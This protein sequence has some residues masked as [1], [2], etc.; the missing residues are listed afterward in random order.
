MG[1]AS[2]SAS[3]A[4]GARS[5]ITPAATASAGA[6]KAGK[7]GSIVAPASVATAV[8]AAGA[9]R[10]SVLCVG[11]TLSTFVERL[12]TANAARSSFASAAAGG[13]FAG[14]WASA[15]SSASSSRLGR[16]GR[17]V[18]SGGGPDSIVPAICCSGTPQNGC[19]AA[20]ASQRRIPTAQ[21]SLAGQ[22]SSP[23]RRSGE[24]YASVPG[25]SP[26]AVSVSASSN[27]ARPKSSTRTETLSSAARSTF[28]GLTSRW[29]IPRPCACARPSRI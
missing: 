11:T 4:R 18:A 19:L 15:W 21:T 5:A 23:R 12:R 25:T 1:A 9:R 22:A 7:N 27:C 3:P 10:T 6:Q 8:A 17:S 20:S 2:A 13:R 29:T 26:T 16:S 14:S 28:D 24:M